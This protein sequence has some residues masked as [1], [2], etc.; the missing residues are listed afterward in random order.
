M[1]AAPGPARRADQKG[2][3]SKAGRSAHE[4]RGKNGRTRPAARSEVAGARARGLREM[5]RG[6]RGDEQAR[7]L[8]GGGVAVAGKA[9]GYRGAVV[10]V[11]GQE[12]TDGSGAR[13]H[14]GRAARRV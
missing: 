6:W 7:E 3:R 14:A 5:R 2:A 12:F 1:D 10:F 9:A 8:S 11:G 13:L 4:R